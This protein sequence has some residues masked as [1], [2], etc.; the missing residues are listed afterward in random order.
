MSRCVHSLLTILVLF[1]VCGSA[2]AGEQKT[3]VKLDL[4]AMEL[5]ADT[6]APAAM[7]GE[8]SYRAVLSGKRGVITIDPWW[9]KTLR[10]KE[11]SAYRAE[12]VFKD[13]AASPV[14]VEAFAGLP[15]RYEL[16]RIGGL[17]AGHRK[18]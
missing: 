14:V 7:E 12:I 13:T 4:A 5:P 9:G 6:W 16:H 10:P 15:G 17:A 2:S 8:R 18:D 1:A 11:G 3:N